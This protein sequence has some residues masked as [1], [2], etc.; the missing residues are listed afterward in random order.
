MT[1]PD[2]LFPL[3]KALQARRLERKLT[4]EQLAQ[5]AGV[6]Y[7]TLTKLESGVIKNPSVQAVSK[8]ARALEISLDSLL[9]P[10]VFAGED[11]VL[12]I[13]R[14]VRATA[15]EPGDYMCISGLEEQAY[16]DTYREG[17][18]QFIAELKTRG[19]RQK[20]LIC[21]GDHTLLEGEHL[22]YRWIPK[23]HFNP[24]PIYVYGS[25]LAVLIW[26][27]IRQ[28][29][30]LDNELLADAYRKQFLFIWEHAVPVPRAP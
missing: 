15:L 27:P 11:C 4:Q 5:R 24:T 21:E 16:L 3:G 19:V 6:P 14:D 13:W 20:L 29:L 30:I 26:Q 23:G 10:H 9:V 22:E 1:K 28:A 17:L 12:E 25:K 2:Q 18:L 8:L 7:T